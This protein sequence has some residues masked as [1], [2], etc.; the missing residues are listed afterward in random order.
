MKI[1]AI[2][3]YLFAVSHAIP[4]V[5]QRLLSA[6]NSNE[7]LLGVVNPNILQV[8]VNPKLQPGMYQP[9]L[10][11][12][13]GL[14]Q[15]PLNARSGLNTQ[16][17]NQMMSYV[18]P[19]GV[20][21]KQGQM[22]IFPIYPAQQQPAQASPKQLGNEPAIEQAFRCFVPQVNGE[23]IIPSSGLQLPARNSND[24]LFLDENPTPVPNHQKDL[25]TPDVMRAP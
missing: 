20:P 16:L 18:V 8:S 2:L 1:L 17:P 21:Q 12:I 25:V 6:S 4:L 19:F 23:V 5:A 3:V 14:P 10:R 22:Q 24:P 15:I 7:V 11:K 9:Q 13:A